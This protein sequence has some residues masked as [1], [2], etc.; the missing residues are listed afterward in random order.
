MTDSADD[1]DLTHPKRP[2]L[3]PPVD[4]GKDVEQQ[5][6]IEHQKAAANEG[7][8]SP[9]PAEVAPAG[10]ASNAPQHQWDL[11]SDVVRPEEADRL[12]LRD[13]ET[14]DETG[15]EFGKFFRYWA[16][17]RERAPDDPHRAAA[18]SMFRFAGLSLVGGLGTAGAAEVLANPSGLDQLYLGGGAG[19]VF[20]LIGGLINVHRLRRRR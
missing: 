9:S 5:I 14:E 13:I 6:E 10:F 7:E 16:R 1:S 2:Q 4:A 17:T 20:L 12:V 3:P 18:T 15:F 11:T 19:G 8:I